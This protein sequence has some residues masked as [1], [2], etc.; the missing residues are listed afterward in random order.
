[1]GQAVAAGMATSPSRSAEVV[2]EEG[3]V[4]GEPAASLR[5]VAPREAGTA[6]SV[7][8]RAKQ[9]MLGVAEHLEP[10][11]GCRVVGEQDAT[12]LRAAVDGLVE[13]LG[14]CWAGVRA[15]H[16]RLSMTRRARLAAIAT[17]ESIR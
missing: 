3:W 11:V 14:S 8:R 15:G 12:A 2:I 17:Q 1:M 16:S 7:S 13:L 9:D 4:L 6:T 10:F 5:A